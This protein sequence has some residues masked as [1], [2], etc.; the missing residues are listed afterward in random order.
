MTVSRPFVY[1]CFAPT[2]RVPHVIPLLLATRNTH[3]T[4]EV[5]EI[6]GAAFEIRDLSAHPEIPETIETGKTFQENATSKALAASEKC[7]GLVMADD[8]GLEVEALD[9]APGIY[10]ARY[11]GKNATALK[12]IE[13]LL[14]ELKGGG[15]TASTR[16]ARFRCVIALARSGKLL[17]TVEGVVKGIIVDPP[18]GST[19][20]GYDPVFQPEGFDQTFGELPAEIKNRI[21][22][23]AKAIEKLSKTNLLSS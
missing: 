22:H 5:Q 20:F 11:A 16:A 1:A 7:P 3:K 15:V 14:A 13:K 17:R 6:F 10:S 4:R 23:R 18:R 12:N 21:S 2:V 8:S 19:G 9:G